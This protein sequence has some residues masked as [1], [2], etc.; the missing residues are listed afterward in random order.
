MNCSERYVQKDQTGTR[1]PYFK[2]SGGQPIH[3]A[4]LRN[5]ANSGPVD[6]EPSLGSKRGEYRGRQQQTLG[7]GS[8]PTISIR[9]FRLD[10]VS[11][12]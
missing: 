11:S 8:T 2:A 12:W 3:S 9:N 10:N 4:V 5:M 7:C 6:G 1:I